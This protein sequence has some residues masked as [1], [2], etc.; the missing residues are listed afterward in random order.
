MYDVDRQW[1]KK[2]GG[3][4]RRRRREVEI[5]VESRPSGLMRRRSTRRFWLGCP[6]AD[7][8][9]ADVSLPA[10]VRTTEGRRDQTVLGLSNSHPPY[11]HTTNPPAPVNLYTIHLSLVTLLLS[12]PITQPVGVI[13]RSSFSSCPP[14]TFHL[15]L[16]L[17]PSPS[18]LP[19]FLSLLILLLL[20]LPPF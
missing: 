2:E 19:L 6:S 12:G 3:R 20:N 7:R 16:P 4:R 11:T 14:P 15:F 9:Q 5:A 17:F 8:M 18:Y 10:F 13:Y 1:R